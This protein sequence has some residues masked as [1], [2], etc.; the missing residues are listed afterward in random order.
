MKVTIIATVFS[1]ISL[2]NG[3]MGHLTQFS[4]LSVLTLLSEM[5]FHTLILKDIGRNMSCV[6][7]QAKIL[8]EFSMSA[9]T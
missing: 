4:S 1:H 3:N 8:T 9:E 2:F 6:T 7:Q 5:R